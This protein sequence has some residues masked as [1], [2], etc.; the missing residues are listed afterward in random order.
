MFRSRGGALRRR[1][2]R[3]RTLVR[4][5]LRP[6][7]HPDPDAPPAMLEAERLMGL[8]Q[9]DQAAEHFAQ[10]ARGAV[11]RAM[12]EAAGDLYLRAARCYVE[13][14]DIEQADRCAEQAIHLFIQA[15]RPR[16]VRQVLRRVLAAL[17]RRGR[18]DDA[19]R[20]RREVEQAFQGMEP[21]LG[22]VPTAVHRGQL[23]AKCATCGGP[24]K[25]DEVAWSDPNNAECPYCGGVVKAE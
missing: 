9:F 19:E 24:L 17:E 2:F 10:L 15:R 14:N 8:G 23:P 21:L 7:L 18:H 25:P 12:P 11:D 1:P 20:L 5:L 4:R 22:P 16:R 6:D 13:T 3:R